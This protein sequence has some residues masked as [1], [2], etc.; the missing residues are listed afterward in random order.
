M[1]NVLV[2]CGNDKGLVWIIFSGGALFFVVT[3]SVLLTLLSGTK[4]I[5][6]VM[7]KEILS[8]YSCRHRQS[9]CS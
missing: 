4:N 5:Y 1:Y 6:W 3:F 7:D 2:Y 9:I 8:G